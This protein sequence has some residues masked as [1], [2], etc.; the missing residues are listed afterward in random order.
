M[1][2]LAT[3][4][5]VLPPTP[6]WMASLYADKPDTRLT[7]VVIPGTHDS[8]AFRIDTEGKCK[9]TAIAGANPAMA[10]AAKSNPC[11][12][13]RLAKAQSQNFTSQLNGGVRYL[14][15]RLG[16]PETKVVT[17]KKAGKKLTN[18][19]AA[20][21][22][23]Y[24]QHTFTSIR[25]TKALGQILGFA[26][27]HPREQIILDFQHIDLTGK[28]KVD[29]YYTTAI[30]K[31]LRTYRVN[32]T[33]VCS[34]AWTAGKFPDVTQTTFG[35]AWQADRNILVLYAK[36]QLP[37]KSCYRQREQILYSPWPNTEDPA[38]S[39][40]ANAGY[41]ANR[42]SALSGSASCTVAGG[43]QCGLF[44]DQLQLSMGLMSQVQCLTGARTQNCSLLELAQLR[45]PSVVQEMTDWKAAALPVNISIVDFYE[46][47]DTARGQIALNLPG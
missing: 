16:V 6:D 15:M 24:L 27:Q 29:K 40:T 9:L 4:L 20:K 23:V 3:A 13:G 42:Q 11:A 30:D 17:P 19:A 8:G 25:F 46:V 43:N 28:K 35:Q 18:Q 31:I 37:A 10:S 22:P 47:N 21:V 34:R 7:Q 2:L 41:L 39:Q 14:D 12:V 45:N 26:K 33:S 32:G 5:A 36:G 1:L 44:V 38:V